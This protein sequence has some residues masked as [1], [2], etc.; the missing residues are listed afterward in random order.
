MID[1]LSRTLQAVFD[2]AGIAAAF[3]EL[4]NALISFEP[5]TD[6]FAPTQTTVNLFLY[7]IRENTELRT[8]Q[9]VVVRRNGQTAIQ[10]PPLRI[11]CSYLVTA[12][13]VTA[14]D[15]PLLEQRLLSQVLMLLARHPTVPDALLQGSLA[16]QEPPL[17]MISA[18]ADGLKNPAEFWSALGNKLR[19]SLTVVVTIGMQPFAAETAPAVVTSELRLGA[20]A[21]PD[22]FKLKAGTVAEGFVIGGRVADNADAAIAAAQV[23]LVGTAHAARTDAD[24]HYALGPLSAGAYTLRVTAPGRAPK[25]V[26]INVPAAAGTD[27]NVKLS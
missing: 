4:F 24:G 18:H 26:S 15:A 27:Y 11:A 22:A 17:P 12:W 16:G 8:S 5:P 21:A 19:P 13:P 23:A 25:D 10:R 7:D 20:R 2:D 9:P 1:D 6:K 14:T 3:P